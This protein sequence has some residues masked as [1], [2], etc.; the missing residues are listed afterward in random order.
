[1]LKE[2]HKNWYATNNMILVIVGDTNPVA[3][4]ARIKGLFGGVPSHSIPA[5]TPLVLKAVHSESFTLE[6]DLPNIIGV[7]AFR[8]PGTDSPDYAATRVLIDVL[9]SGVATSAGWNHQARL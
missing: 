6:S 3:T 2:F 9:S 8:F 5:R 7:V 4:L 1:M